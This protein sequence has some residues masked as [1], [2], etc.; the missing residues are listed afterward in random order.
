MQDDFSRSD[1]T[2]ANWR[3][4]PFN[5]WSFQNVAEI[6]PS[7]T[8]CEV[9]GSE[10]PS[11]ENSKLADPVL[12]DGAGGKISAIGH[13]ESASTDSFVALRD[14]KIIA[15]WNAPNADPALPHVIFSISKSVT[16]ML[17]G[18]AAEE[19]RL[20]PDAPITDYVDVPTGG[21]YASALVRH[22]LDMTV[23][24]DF[25]EAYL[26]VG[27][28][29]DRY[30]R[31]MLWNPEGPGTVTETMEQ[32][33]VSL[34]PIAGEAH[35]TRFHYASPN[36]D[37]L[38]LV[39]ERATGRRYHEYLA[40]KIWK[41][42]GAT[43]PARVTVDR[44]GSARAA[45]GVCVTPA[46][47]ARFGEL[48]L[49]DGVAHDGTRLIPSGWID[50]MHQ[51]G[52][53]AAWVKGDFAALLPAGRYRSCWYETGDDHGSFFG[54]GIHE[55]WLWCDPTSRVVIAKTSSRPEPSN[56]EATARNILILSQLARLL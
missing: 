43:G 52:D 37:M 44:V 5:R 38:G 7:A 36:T 14:G 25:D 18:I 40:E 47:L 35:G 19:G 34:K 16:G 48:V 27:G 24:L 29:F 45:G 15:A 53:T 50:D 10:A 1:V 55:Q 17:A 31:A 12:D 3:T 22:L 21:A 41:P 23:S 51:N 13:F 20:D 39:I 46:D 2:L 6:V 4:S 54:I 9:T 56:D 32:C 8:I 30:R 11:P 28:D 49:R 33:L 42:M 26:D